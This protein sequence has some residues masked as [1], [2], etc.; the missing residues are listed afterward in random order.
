MKERGKASALFSRYR[1][2]ERVAVVGLTVLMQYT[3]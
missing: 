3:C 1:V 2:M